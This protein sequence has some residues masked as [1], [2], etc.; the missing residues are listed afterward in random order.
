MA[1]KKVS[2]LPDLPSA[3]ASGDYALIDRAGD[4]YKVAGENIVLTTGDQTIAGTKTFSSAP[5]VTGSGFV[6]TTGDQTIAGTKTFS[7]APVFP[8]TFIDSGTYTPT[9]SNTTNV[10]ASTA[11]VCNWFRIK[12]MVTVSGFVEIDITTAT[13]ATTLGM[14]IPVASN[15]TANNQ[16]VGTAVSNNGDSWRIISDSTNDRMSFTNSTQ[17]NT[18][19]LFYTFIFTYKVI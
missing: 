8:A 13:T 4:G 18:G 14:S 6:L 19:N 16:G 3:L 15:F 11:Y 2:E 5:A 10:S 9:L 1:I 7:S 12:D 17:S